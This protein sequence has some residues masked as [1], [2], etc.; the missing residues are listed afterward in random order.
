MSLAEIKS[1][2]CHFHD[3]I[4]TEYSNVSVSSVSHQDGWVANTPAPLCQA[5]GQEC[6]SFHARREL[7]IIRRSC[8]VTASCVR[9]LCEMEQRSRELCGVSSADVKCIVM[10]LLTE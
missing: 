8:I 10:S 6:R 7:A 2:K 5:A 1:L 4:G 9:R 3:N